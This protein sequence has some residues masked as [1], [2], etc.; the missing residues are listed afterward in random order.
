[1]IQGQDHQGHLKN[2]TVAAALY[3]RGTSCLLKVLCVR[4]IEGIIT[5]CTSV[6]SLKE[7]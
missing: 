7:K 2:N 1:M 5:F 4:D 6:D 3:F